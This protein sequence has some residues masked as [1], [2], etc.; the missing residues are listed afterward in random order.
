MIRNWFR[1]RVDPL[2]QAVALTKESVR[3]AMRP[4]EDELEQ[5]RLAA[6]A[7]QAVRQRCIDS[8]S[9]WYATLPEAHSDHRC[10]KCGST[11]VVRR[12]ERMGQRHS[13]ECQLGRM[14]ESLRAAGYFSMWNPGHRLPH[15]EVLQI[16]C[17]HCG[18]AIGSERT[19][20]TKVDES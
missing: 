10:V 14:R 19:L 7:R 18:H 12:F 1:P 2:E 6:E 20:D 9:D 15:R 11:R 8:E 5:V 17:A 3:E 16:S 4:T 13:V